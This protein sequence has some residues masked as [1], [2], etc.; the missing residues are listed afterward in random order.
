MRH[1]QKLSGGMTQHEVATALGISQGLVLHIEQS[2]FRKLRNLPE[3]RKLLELVRFVPKE[4]K[5]GSE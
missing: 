5:H 4:S 3:A 1:K 2:A